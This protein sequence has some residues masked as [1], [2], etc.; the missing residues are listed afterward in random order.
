MTHTAD[1]LSGEAVDE[2]VDGSG[3][4]RPAWRRVFGVVRA[5][6]APALNE[7]R[8]LLD[9]LATDE[10]A[11]GIRGDGGHPIWRCDPVPLVLSAGEFAVIADGLGQRA[12]LLDRVI[13]DLL[14]PQTLFASGHV[15]P[16]AVLGRRSFVRPARF[17]VDRPRL[18]LYAAD[19][20]RAADGRWRV[21]NDLCARPAGVGQVLEQRAQLRRAMPELFRDEIP[22]PDRFFER[23]RE[24]LLALRPANRDGDGALAVLGEGFPDPDWFEHV[25]LAR[26][27]GCALVQGADLTVRGGLLWQK[28]LTGLQRVDILIGR[29]DPSRLDPLELDWTAGAGV[30]GLMAL[31]R[32]GRVGFANDPGAVLGEAPALAAFLPALAPLVLG[33]RLRLEGPTT[34]WLGDPTSL[35]ACAPPGEGWLIRSATDPDAAPVDPGALGT[36][37]R[38]RLDAEIAGD[39]GRFVAVEAIA[40]SVAPGAG[41]HGLEAAPVVLRLFLLR[42]GDDRW[43]ALPSGFGRVLEPGEHP[44]APLRRHG[45]AKHLLLV[46]SGDEDATT[47]AA[48]SAAVPVAP[49]RPPGGRRRPVRIGDAEIPARVAAEFYRLGQAS[50]ELDGIARLLRALIPRLDRFGGRPRER[51]ELGLLGAALRRTAIL[52][53]ELI[54]EPGLVGTAGLAAPLVRLDGPLGRRVRR[55]ARRLDGLRDRLGV[56][57]VAILARSL[58]DVL[59]RFAPGEPGRLPE[60]AAAILGFSATLAGI[61][62]ESMIRGGGRRFLELG[63]AIVRAETAAAELA[64]GLGDA[65]T[66][67]LP[68]GGGLRSSPD[69]DTTLAML[70]ELRDSLLTYRGR[71]PGPIE[72][73]LALHLL[74]ADRGN[75]RAIGTALESAAVLLGGGADGGDAGPTALRLRERA[76]T[77]AE[78]AWNEDDAEAAAPALEVRLD[79]LARAIGALRGDVRRR[80]LELLPPRRSLDGG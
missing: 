44:G 71:Y 29:Q 25:L 23:W 7:R 20:I 31:I 77:I 5:L 1:P 18:V 2:M 40:P 62:A 76:D 66:L 47:S 69:L 3:R 78:T 54:A 56:G 13:A 24:R 64:L 38:R 45:T 17:G 59:D 61:A 14:G 37:A 19:L 27:L 32:S 50:E 8:R 60:I 51:V 42:D 80:M 57:T 16:L 9:R 53:D 46:L 30:P 73:G 43:M 11:A 12:R 79:T 26:S 34:C 75:P 58:G 63:R 74:L 4:V 67:P 65:A 36:R 48:L 70:L 21:V 10:G 49:P 33:E 15:P 39:P 28:H 52:P 35:E 41:P 55:E 6:G 22:A 68:S 72:P